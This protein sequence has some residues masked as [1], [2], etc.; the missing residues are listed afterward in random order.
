MFVNYMLA[1]VASYYIGSYVARSAAY[2]KAV[3]QLPSSV[4][5]LAPAALAGLVLFGLHETGALKAV[6]KAI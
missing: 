5:S 1:G 3:A 6:S 2:A 4:Q